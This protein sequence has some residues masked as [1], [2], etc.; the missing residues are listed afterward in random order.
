MSRAEQYELNILCACDENYAPYTGVSITSILE[1]NRQADSVTIYLAPMGFS[2]ETVQKMTDLV[3][4]YQRKIVFLD[5]EKAVEQIHAYNCAGWNGSMATWLRFFV[6]EQ[7]PEHVHRLLWVDSDTAVC[8]SLAE[9][10]QMDMQGCP[11]GAVCD[12]LCFHDRKRLDMGEDDSYYNAGVLLFDLDL[13]RPGNLQQQMMAHLACNVSRY[14]LNDQDLLNDF[15]RGRILRLP[16]CYN[17]QGIHLAYTVKQ[18]FSVFHW[19]PSAFYTPQELQAG[20]EQPAIVH[21]LRFLGNYP[22]EKGDNLHPAKPLY[23][24][25]KKRS[26]WKDLPAAE[27]KKGFLFTVE[28]MVYR[29]LPRGVFLRIFAWVWSR[30]Y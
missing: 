25:W 8:G 12:S 14:A 1:N 4:Q 22:W 16:V 2:A 29:I 6:L 9:L 10:M 30:N 17:L 13:W 18:Y 20:I 27:P 19:Q 5:T 24:A 28:K 26:P 3:H 7:I 21:F 15:F 23:E 11:V